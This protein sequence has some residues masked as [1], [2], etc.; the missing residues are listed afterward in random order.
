MKHNL[1]PINSDTGNYETMR[2]KTFTLIELLVVIAIIAILAAMLLPALSKARDAAKATTCLNNMKQTGIG[3]AQYRTDFNDI[4]NG[5]WKDSNTFPVY[6]L[7][8]NKYVTWKTVGCPA[9]HNSKFSVW[10]SYATNG[11][12]YSQYF[13]K[14]NGDM[15]YFAAKLIKK[16]SQ[17]T[18]LIDCITY[19]GT[20]FYQFKF[21]GSYAAESRCTLYHNRKGTMGFWDGHVK[22]VNDTKA[23]E[24]GFT[25]IGL[26][27]G[28]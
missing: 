20:M 21:K 12:G 22:M 14:W 3:F 10:A 23:K 24:Y 6:L 26:R 18:F 25:S 11:E 13:A 27:V 17:E 28:L 4:V 19:T 5:T 9:S 1:F 7:C 2:K 15:W 16:P 8:D